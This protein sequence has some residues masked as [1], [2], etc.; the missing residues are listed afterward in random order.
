MMR[1]LSI[2]VGIKNLA[3]CLFTI[4]EKT[5]EIE[6]WEVFDLTQPS[7]MGAIYSGGGLSVP[8]SDS[9]AMASAASAASATTSASTP[10]FPP[11]YN[12]QP[13]CCFEKK[14]CKR[15]VAYHKFG[16][17][18]CVMHAK[19]SDFLMPTADW[20]PSK[21][22]TLSKSALGTIIEQHKIDLPN[23]THNKQNYLDA[24]IEYAKLK[25]LEPVVKV[26]ANKLDLVTIGQ[27][28][29]RAFSHFLGDTKVNAVIIE[30]QISPI[31]AR[32]KTIQGMIAQYFIMKGVT[33][34]EFISASNKLRGFII[35]SGG[36]GGVT[37]EVSSG[38]SGLKGDPIGEYD[39]R[40]ATDSD[41]EGPPHS[42]AGGDGGGGGGAG[43]GGGHKNKKA[44][45][46]RKSASIEI[47]R[48]MLGKNSVLSKWNMF[49][50]EHKKKD[51]L[52]DCFLQGLWYIREKTIEY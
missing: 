45:Q 14:L 7:M 42:G 39:E 1:L 9:A 15:P 32:M 33:S 13:V 38:H 31:A 8:I 48:E 41:E 20:K 24:V 18:F 43:S 5:Y 17:H 25:T 52:A 6:A 22:R 19:K 29:M 37:G 46:A 3:A 21:L 2:D 44:Y 11:S 40:A 16:K 23:T 49:F 27:G 51:D 34:I 4:G 30:N 12:S 36:T 35:K 10:Y 47:V 50:M 26:K 28:I